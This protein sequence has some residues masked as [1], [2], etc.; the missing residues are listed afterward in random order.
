MDLVNSLVLSIFV[1]K[2][3]HPLHCS[4]FF[5]FYVKGTIRVRQKGVH[6]FLLLDRKGVRETRVK[7]R[8]RG[9]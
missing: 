5:S 2:G 7:K 6:F 4:V 8:R 3:F 1:M 9:T